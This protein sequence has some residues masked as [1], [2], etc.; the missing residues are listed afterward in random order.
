MM[1]ELNIPKQMM[2]K[3]VTDGH[4]FVTDG[5]YAV[6]KVQVSFKDIVFKTWWRFDVRNKIITFDACVV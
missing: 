3:L 6:Q 1:N 2:N 5:Q 4:T